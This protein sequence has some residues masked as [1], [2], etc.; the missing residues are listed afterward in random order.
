MVYML[1]GFR[2]NETEEEIL[3]RFNEMRA[4]GCRPYPMVFDRTNKRLCAFQRWVIRRYYEFVP[5]EKYGVE[6][7]AAKRLSQKVLPF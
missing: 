1:V 7:I 6:K 4:L 3:Y 5:W 2:K